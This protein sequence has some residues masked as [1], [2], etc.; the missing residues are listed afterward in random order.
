[1]G[2]IR[3]DGVISGLISLFFVSK[4]KSLYS[5]GGSYNWGGALTWDFVANN[6][7]YFNIG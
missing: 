4:W 1:M 3:G 7:N 6:K 2:Y 5:G